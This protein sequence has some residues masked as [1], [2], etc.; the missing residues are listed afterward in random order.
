MRATDRS[1]VR[2]TDLPLVVQSQVAQYLAESATNESEDGVPTEPGDQGFAE[3]ERPLC[4][5]GVEEEGHP[6]QQ[7]PARS[8]LWRARL[9]HQAPL[10]REVEDLPTQAEDD[11]KDPRHQRIRERG[12][13]LFRPSLQRFPVLL[14]RGHPLHGLREAVLRG[15]LGV[16]TCGVPDKD[17]L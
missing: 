6:A 13:E 12:L 7:R 8:S 16:R 9:V 14:P 4:G 5:G 10:L 1:S 15:W 3:A 17:R 11:D 2:Q